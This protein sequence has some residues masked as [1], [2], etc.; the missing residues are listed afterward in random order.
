MKFQAKLK[1]RFDASAPDA[2][3]QLETDKTLSCEE[4]KEDMALLQHIRDNLPASLGPVNV[5]RVKRLKRSA[6]IAEMKAEQV[7]KEKE[8]R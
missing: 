8:R 3:H 1:T 6:E 4:R 7:L 5:W 2:L